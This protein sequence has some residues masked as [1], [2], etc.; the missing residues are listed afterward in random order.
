MMRH[1]LL[2][3]RVDHPEILDE[4][5]ASDFETRRSLEDLRRLNQ[6]LFGTRVTLGVLKTW[7]LETPKPATVLELGTGSGQMAQALAQWAA[8]EY[9]AV[10][11]LALDFMPQHLAIARDWNRTEGCPH[12]QL[13][14]GNALSLPLADGSVDFVTSSLFLHHFSPDVLQGLFAECRRV[15][16]RGLAM[17][18]LWRHPLPYYLYKG[19]AEPLFVR[20][21]IT[22]ADS[23][24][25]FHRAYQPME[26]ERIAKEA[27]P[28]AEV[29]VSLDFP[30]LRWLLT[31]RWE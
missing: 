30:S 17:S 21:P 16:R 10:R 24:A 13:V 28:E 31:A 3:K 14:G 23:A 6:W 9:Q 12:I 29:K 4:G 27:L 8:R 11:V 26:I 7:L 22:H 25:S 20:S 2:Q 19:A 15:A 1:L 18:D 5:L